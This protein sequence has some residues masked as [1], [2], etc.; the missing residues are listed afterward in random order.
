MPENIKSTVR[1]FADDT[2]VYLAI[3]SDV[4]R[5]HLQ[6]DLDRLAHWEQTWKMGFHLGKCNV[7]SIT[8]KRNSVI[9]CYI[10]HGHQLEQVQSAKY[11]GVSITSDMKWSEHITNICKKANNTLSFLKRKLNTSNSNLKDKAYQSLVR[12]TQG[13]ACT[14]WDPH[15]QNNKHSIEMVQRR[16]ATRYVKN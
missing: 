12:P 7:M 11:L 1:L 4:D 6:E 10:L 3:T 2:I 16:G 9:N 14:T 5:V 8:K 15:Q 13:Y